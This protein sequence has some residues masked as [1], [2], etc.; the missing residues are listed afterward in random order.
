MESILISCI[1][2]S[3][4]FTTFEYKMSL[5]VPSAMDE[6][7]SSDDVAKPSQ[8]L[9]FPQELLL[10]DWGQGSGNCLPHVAKSPFY[11]LATEINS[12]L[13]TGYL[14]CWEHIFSQLIRRIVIKGFM[15]IDPRRSTHLWSFDRLGLFP[16]R[17]AVYLV[18][19]PNP[20]AVGRWDVY[21]TAAQRD[22]GWGNSVRHHL[23]QLDHAH[24]TAKVD[25]LY[26]D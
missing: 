9:L 3:N 5:S 16:P 2:K 17:W 26:S 20:F 6:W 12:S 4:P 7:S 15:R 8:A 24:T 1:S 14:Y 13:H 18:R 19:F 10:F 11:A 25:V 23:Q 21:H 22:W